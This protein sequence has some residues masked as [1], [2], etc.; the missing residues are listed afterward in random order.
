MK[1]KNILFLWILKCPLSFNY[2][3]VHWLYY[4]NTYML[5]IWRECGLIYE[6]THPENTQL[7]E[8]Y[9][10]FHTTPEIGSLSCLGRYIMNAHVKDQCSILLYFI[11][12]FWLSNQI[13]TLKGYK[14]LYDIQHGPVKQYFEVW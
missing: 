9:V 2:S 4:Q 10:S 7:Q 6:Q 8:T 12:I 13:A 5:F 11:F 1:I 3:Y 14:V